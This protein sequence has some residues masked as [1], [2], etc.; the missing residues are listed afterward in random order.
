METLR[1]M[2]KWAELSSEEVAERLGVCAQQVYRYEVGLTR[3]PVDLVI[4]MARLYRCDVM[5]IILAATNAK[6]R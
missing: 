2:R 5:D 3:L 4:P 1:E 6:M